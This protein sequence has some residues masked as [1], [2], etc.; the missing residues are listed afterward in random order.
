MKEAMR[1]SR[2][3]ML[4]RNALG[5]G[6]SCEDDVLQHLWEAHIA[7]QC[8]P[9]RRSCAGKPGDDLFLV[10]ERLDSR[11]SLAQQS[12]SHMRGVVVVRGAARRLGIR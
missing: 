9:R 2:F 6:G 11:D 5:A 8:Q 4:L 12:H 10:K 3:P 7:C 1:K